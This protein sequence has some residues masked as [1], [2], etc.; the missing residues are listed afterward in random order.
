MG[1]FSGDKTAKR[2]A[3]RARKEEA[4]RQARIK[5]GTAAID[6][7]FGTFNDSFYDTIARNAEN[8]QLP[9]VNQDYARTQGQLGFNLAGRGLLNSSVRD[10]RTASLAEELTKTKRNIADA[11]LSQ[12]NKLRMD[13]EDAR[14]RSYSQLLQ[15]ADPS[16]AT[17]S[18][19][20]AASALS[21]PSPIGPAGS[22]FNDWTQI[23]LTNKAAKAE[24]PDVQ[25]LFNFSGGSS[26][27]IG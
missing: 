19:T 2:E 23:Y 27:T 22:F 14:N 21:Q 6:Q 17:A 11:G 10:Q 8:A 9:Q 4:E 3:E 7:T 20:R 18:A 16:Q 24:N 25:P 13:V 26:R 5:A 12:A 15:S 1:F